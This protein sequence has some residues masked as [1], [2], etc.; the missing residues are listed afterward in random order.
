MLD[1]EGQEE[2]KTNLFYF[3]GDVFSVCLFCLAAFVQYAFLM[4]AFLLN[5]YFP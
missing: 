3:P 1:K 5:A 4:N 2:R